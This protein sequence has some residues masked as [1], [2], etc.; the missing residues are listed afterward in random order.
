M[1]FGELECS[2]NNTWTDDGGDGFVPH[3]ADSRQ[4]DAESQQPPWHPGRSCELSTSPLHSHSHQSRNPSY[5]SP[6]VTDMA[7]YDQPLES[8]IANR[9]GVDDTATD[10]V[11]PGRAH[12]QDSSMGFDSTLQLYSASVD[13]MM[14]VMEQPDNIHYSPGTSFPEY[15]SYEDTGVSGHKDLTTIRGPHPGVSQPIL[16]HFFDTRFDNRCLHSNQYP[17]YRY[18]DHEQFE[19][20]KPPPVDT[21]FRE[22]QN[23]EKSNEEEISHLKSPPAASLPVYPDQLASTLGKRPPTRTSK[24]LKSKP[25]VPATRAFGTVTGERT[26]ECRLEPSKEELD[27]APN[28]R[29]KKALKTWY[30][31][32]RQL[33]VYRREHG[34]SKWI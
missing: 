16:F 21:T 13:G 29:A 7:V 32:L 4:Q 12:H 20:R 24:R 14:P 33:D 28:S 8:P 30:G 5:E 23:P 6:R 31:R 22:M 3:D 9:A 19:D 25:K 1:R 27:E 10:L 26:S 15:Q 2:M 18:Q 11:H 17:M 34:H